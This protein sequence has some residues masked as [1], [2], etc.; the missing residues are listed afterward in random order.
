MTT[1]LYAR[2]KLSSKYA[3]Q[4]D[5]PGYPRHF[6]VHIDEK[7]KDDF[8][9]QGGVGSQYRMSDVNI[10]VKLDNGKFQKIGR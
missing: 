10:F 8:I 6:P 1:Q 5:W 7:A 3:N 4:N 2:I 9:V